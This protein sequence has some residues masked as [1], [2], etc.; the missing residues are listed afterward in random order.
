[1]KAARKA[2][3]YKEV[4]RISKN[5][6]DMAFDLGIL[7]KEPERVQQVGAVK[8]TFEVEDSEGEKPKE[9]KPEKTKKDE[10]DKI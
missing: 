1:M 5:I 8:F 3:D 4:S 9:E 2:R 7:E 10:E 6:M